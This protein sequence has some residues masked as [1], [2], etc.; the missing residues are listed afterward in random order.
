MEEETC[1]GPVY[2]LDEVFSDPRVLARNM[3][4]E[5]NHPVLGVLKQVGFPPEVFRR[6]GSRPAAGPPVGANTI[7]RF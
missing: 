3:V 7:T 6:R 1:V 5:T 2:D 4:I